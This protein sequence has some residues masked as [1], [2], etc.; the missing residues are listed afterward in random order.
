MATMALGA[1]AL[2]YYLLADGPAVRLWRWNESVM[3]DYY[4]MLFLE[5]SAPRDAA[6]QMAVCAALALVALFAGSIALLMAVPVAAIAPSM[7]LERR[8]V[9]KGML[10]SEQL[11]PWLTVL[12]NSLK[13]SPNIADAFSASTGL[14]PSPL[15][16]EVDLLVK[17]VR[18]G[19]HLDRAMHRSADRLKS[20]LYSSVMT[21]LLVARKSGGN[22]PKILEKSSD[23][24]REMERLAGVV[25]TKTAEGKSQ[26][27]VLAIL[28]FVMVGALQKVDPTMIPK[29]AESGMGQVILAIAI[30]L[31]LG[32]V[33]LAYRIVQVDI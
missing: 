28:P 29:L 15:R 3:A 16:E 30:A 20:P 6:L 23:T 32:S 19:E 13:S 25:R 22:L 31:W 10:I 8:K 17:E 33:A 18:L 1:G 4:S 12:A 11:A 24:L 5:R 9:A 2:A 14:V 7:V 21:T 27:F 26:T